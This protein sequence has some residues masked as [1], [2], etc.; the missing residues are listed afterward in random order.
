MQI[1]LAK[2]AGYCF[3]VKR[4]I[5]MALDA[6]QETDR[7]Y[8]LGPLIHNT[9]IVN[10]LRKKGIAAIEDSNQMV[11]EVVVIRS[12]GITRNQRQVLTRN[13][14]KLIDAT[15]PYVHKTH[16]IIADMV[17]AGYPILIFGDGNHPEVIGMLSYGDEETKVIFNDYQ[18]TDSCHWQKLCLLSQT[19]QSIEDFTA[20]IG[21]LLPHCNELRA[22]NTIC[23]STSERQMAAIELARHCE[24]M[25]IIGGKNSSNTKML[26]KLCARIT[27]TL[28]IET[29]DELVRDLFSGIQRIG[30]SAGAS[31]PDEMIIRVY[32]KIKEIYG[33]GDAVTSIAQIPSFKEES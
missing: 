27:N 25:V 22:F 33:E 19:T 26:A 15:C 17:A 23:S 7:V 32:N 13:R 1:W 20:I 16:K 30:L 10:Q 9:Q 5:K 14:N 21:R 2:C 24:L 29:E 18:V 31:T 6:R 3:G 11:G 28:H 4:A 12:H 8:T